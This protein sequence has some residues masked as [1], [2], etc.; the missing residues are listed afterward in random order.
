VAATA[1]LDDYAWMQANVA[2]VR[3]AREDLISELR[4]LG[5]RVLPSEAN[6]VFAQ[7]P[8]H[9]GEELYRK[10]RDAGILV[11]YFSRP[12]LMAGVRITVGTPEENRALLTAIGSPRKS[13]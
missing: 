6:F 10:L 4:A 13:T 9:S 3:A 5:F 2:K 8:L 12:E 7:S 1:A 11:R